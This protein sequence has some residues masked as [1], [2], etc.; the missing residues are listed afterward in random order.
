MLGL[1]ARSTWLR[2]EVLDCGSPCAQSGHDT[3][4][5]LSTRLEP[6]NTKPLHEGLP[7]L[8]CTSHSLSGALRTLRVQS[9]SVI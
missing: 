2:W 5:L 4:A 9:N 1:F 7:K 6:L 8:V 3:N